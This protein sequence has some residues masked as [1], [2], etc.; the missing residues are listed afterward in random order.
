MAI[1][2]GEIAVL[3]ALI[4]LACAAALLITG[5]EGSSRASAA[6]LPPSGHPCR[7]VNITAP[8]GGQWGGVGPARHV[9]AHN[10]SCGRARRGIGRMLKFATFPQ[11]P[12]GTFCQATGKRMLCSLGNGGGAPF[13]TFT[14]VPAGTQAEGTL[15]TGIVEDPDV[16]GNYSFAGCDEFP[17]RVANRR[18]CR[19][20]IQV[21]DDATDGWSVMVELWW[22]GKLRSVCFDA[23]TAANPAPGFCRPFAPN[24]S[25]VTLF[26][27]E[28][29]QSVWKAC[30]TRRHHA[31]VPDPRAKQQVCDTPGQLRGKRVDYWGGPGRDSDPPPINFTGGWGAGMFNARA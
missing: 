27:V 11:D 30:W 20:R 18:M 10:M 6:H 5:I 1:R 12:L 24:G 23:N 3:R 14:L 25:P 13:F 15:I 19:T 31:W 29:H 2:P 21:F 9:V 8:G 17:Q 7:D 4:A 16:L 28:T 22:G 26:I